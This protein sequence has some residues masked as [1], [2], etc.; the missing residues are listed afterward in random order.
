M[1]T[2]AENAAGNSI[3]EIRGVA[4]AL[5]AYWSRGMAMAPPGLRWT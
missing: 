5:R 3:A 1:A 4:Q 2:V